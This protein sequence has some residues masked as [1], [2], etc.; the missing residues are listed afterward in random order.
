[1]SKIIVKE[2]P[3]LMSAPNIIAILEGRKTHTRRLV[4]RLAGF[5]KITEFG[6]SDTPGYDWHFRDKQMRWHDISHAL[7]LECCPHGP[8][9]RLWVRETFKNIASGEVKNGYGEVR[10]GFA[11][12]ADGAACWAERPTIIHDLTD[13]PPTG[14]M[15]FQPRPWK[16]SIH[17]PRRASRILL[18][19]TDVRV[20]RLQ[21]ISEADAV[22]EGVQITDEWTGCA[23]DLNGSH[24]KAYR[25]LW[26][27]IN[28]A[29]S[30]DANPSWVWVIQFRR[31]ER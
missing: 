11:Y 25:Y 20:D 19:I 4:R 24:V 21:E 28:G 27:S 30:W 3:I 22:A 6:K 12:K 16:S 26:E 13:K 15:Q 9:D 10:Y 29:G 8:G 14:P 18:E 17:M 31:I 7:L 2:R 5:G 1:M 23:E